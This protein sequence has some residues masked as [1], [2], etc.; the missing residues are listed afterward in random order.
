MEKKKKK[1]QVKLAYLTGSPMDNRTLL[2]AAKLF[3][4]LLAAMVALLILGTMMM[5]NNVILRVL[6]NGFVLFCAY[7]IYW[8][9]GV[10]EGA[11][12]VNL[13]EILYQRQSTGRD[14]DEEER[15]RSYHPMKGFL[16]ALLASVPVFLCAVGLALTAQRVMTSAGV[17]PSWLETLERRDE[18]GGALASYHEVAGM[19]LTDGLR[20]VIRMSIM[21]FVN[22]IGADNRGALLWLERVSPLLV[23]L[24]GVCYGVGYLD[25]VK[26]R[27][28]VHAE[29]EAGKKKIK[30]RQKRERRQRESGDRGPGQLN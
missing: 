20:L 2:T 10:N 8:Q 7:M 11:V 30:R 29:I 5:W 1:P 16:I 13:G 19:T 18:I 25:G 14:I 23:L 28:K 27:T 3:G 6:A 15:K 26:V 17:L 22:I 24:P 9:A 21:P 12:A 4:G